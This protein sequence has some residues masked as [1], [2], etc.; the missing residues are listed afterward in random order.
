ME[1]QDAPI[2]R[3]FGSA[4]HQLPDNLDEHIIHHARQE[5][6]IDTPVFVVLVFAV[7]LVAGFLVGVL[8]AL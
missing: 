1:S 7:M 8:L 2:I 4:S 5:S 6:F 3:H